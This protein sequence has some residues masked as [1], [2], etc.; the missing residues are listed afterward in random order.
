MILGR[1]AM[2]AVLQTHQRG[3]REKRSCIIQI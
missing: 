3:V 1:L 2:P